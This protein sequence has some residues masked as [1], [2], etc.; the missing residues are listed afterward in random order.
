MAFAYIR[1]FLSSLFGLDL[2][3]RP[4]TV[5]CFNETAFCQESNVNVLW[6]AAFFMDIRKEGGKEGRKKQRNKKDTLR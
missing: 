5:L 4:V 1:F 6:L 2:Q 3:E